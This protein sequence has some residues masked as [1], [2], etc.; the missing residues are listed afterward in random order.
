MKNIKIARLSGVLSEMTKVA[1]KAGVDM[2]T[3]LV[4]QIIVEGITP[5]EWELSTVV[6]CIRR[7]AILYKEEARADIN[8]PGFEDSCKNYTTCR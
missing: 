6:N 8:R 1:R 5:A 3:D 4:N 2:I 7:K